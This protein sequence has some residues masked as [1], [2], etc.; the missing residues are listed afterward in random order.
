MKLYL[1]LLATSQILS[2][3][4]HYLNTRFYIRILCIV[5]FYF[6]QWYVCMFGKA[7]GSL[8]NISRPTML[9]HCLKLYIYISSC[10]FSCRDRLS[11]SMRTWSSA[12]GPDATLGLLPAFLPH[13][14]SCKQ[15]PVWSWGLKGGSTAAI[16]PQSV[17]TLYYNTEKQTK[18]MGEQKFKIIKWQ[19]TI[20]L[21]I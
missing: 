13:L 4:T 17:K 10:G 2:F 6:S 3:E 19:Q 18:T 14:Q 15:H 7:T 21:Q 20:W 5:H 1:F 16:D 11:Q 12:F 8:F 9:L